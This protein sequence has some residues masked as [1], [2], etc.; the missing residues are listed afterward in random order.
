MAKLNFDDLARYIAKESGSSLRQVY[1][2]LENEEIYLSLKQPGG[3]LSI[4]AD[5]SGH[6]V[7]G[8]RVITL[9]R[10][11]VNITI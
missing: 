5:A 2:Y 8:G 9:S 11:T 7:L 6:A 3:T 10:K 4:R 1:D